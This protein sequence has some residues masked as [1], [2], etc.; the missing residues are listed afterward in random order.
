MNN[1][2]QN[3]ISSQM[4]NMK[5]RYHAKNGSPIDRTVEDTWRRVARGLSIFERERDYWEKEFF[6]CLKEKPDIFDSRD[7]KAETIWEILG[8]QSLKSLIINMP[9]TYP[10]KQ[11]KGAIVSSF[12]TPP[13]SSFVY[14]KKLQ[15]NCRAFL[16]GTEKETGIKGLSK[17][18]F[19][20]PKKAFWWC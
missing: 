8:D 9:V 11:M 4:W 2:N 14:P 7:I 1:D 12:L 16:R 18:I 10:L 5:Y 17:I 6:E 13:G 3:D 20:G 15:K 19:M